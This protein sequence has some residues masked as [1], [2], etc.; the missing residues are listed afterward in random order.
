[1]SFFGFLKNAMKSDIKGLEDH[2]RSADQDFY[3]ASVILFLAFEW[4]V[5]GPYWLMARQPVMFDCRM[6]RDVSCGQNDPDGIAEGSDTF[7]RSHDL[8]M[9]LA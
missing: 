6:D 9:S 1:M 7:N 5:Q 4:G 8:S 2:H 3:E